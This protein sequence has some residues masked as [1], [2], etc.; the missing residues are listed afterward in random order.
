[1]GGRGPRLLHALRLQ[2]FVHRSLFFIASFVFVLA[3]CISSAPTRRG[4]SV[5][6]PPHC[7]PPVFSLIAKL[8]VCILTT[9]LG[10]SK[11]ASH[12]VSASEAEE[13][14]PLRFGSGPLQERGEGVSESRE[15]GQMNVHKI[16]IVID[17]FGHKKL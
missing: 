13:R 8:W 2:V 9:L 10:K 4:T 11:F 12:A 15:S 16:I 7:A 3:A 5:S 1:M 17:C 14:D 6:P